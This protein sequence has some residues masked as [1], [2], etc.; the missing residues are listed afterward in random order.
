[1]ERDDSMAKEKFKVAIYCRIG[2]YDESC[3]DRQET[4][5]QRYCK[6]K[7]YEIYK[8]YV[9][10]G[11][12]AINNKRPDYNLMLEDM[13]AKKFNLICTMDIKFSF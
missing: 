5:I 4:L 3:I 2:N 7:G 13:K 12:S 1:M 9:D 8:S 10:N 6:E 11:Y